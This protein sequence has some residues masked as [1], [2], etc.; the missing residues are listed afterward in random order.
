MARKANHFGRTKKKREKR[1]NKKGNFRQRNLN[2]NQKKS[3]GENK[4]LDVK[5]KTMARKRKQTKCEHFK[6]LI[7]KDESNKRSEEQ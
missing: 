2:G 3:S 5:N 4:C 7:I 1:R 6:S